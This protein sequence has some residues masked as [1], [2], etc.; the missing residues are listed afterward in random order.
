[1]THEQMEIDLDFNHLISLCLHSWSEREVV[2][3]VEKLRKRV[4][5]EQKSRNVKE[6]KS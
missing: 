5:A 6:I 2:A 3:F 4:Q 1:M